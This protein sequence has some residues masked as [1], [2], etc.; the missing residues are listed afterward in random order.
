MSLGCLGLSLGGQGEVNIHLLT[1]LHRCAEKCVM[2]VRLY[3]TPGMSPW[4]IF[5][6]QEHIERSRYVFSSADNQKKV[7]KSECG[8]R[9]EM[10]EYDAQKT[11]GMGQL[12]QKCHLCIG[13]TQIESKTYRCTCSQNKMEKVWQKPF[14]RIKMEEVRPTSEQEA[15]MRTRWRQVRP[16]ATK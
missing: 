14:W 1:G 10:T 16:I 11:W 5:V 8:R 9:G 12:F 6:K 13:A 4:Y 7:T 15:F 3:V 2:Y